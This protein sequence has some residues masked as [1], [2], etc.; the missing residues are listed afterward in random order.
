MKWARTN[1]E[2]L[3]RLK[4][5]GSAEVSEGGRDGV[6]IVDVALVPQESDSRVRLVPDCFRFC[7]RRLIYTLFFRF[8]DGGFSFTD[9]Q[10]YINLYRNS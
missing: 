7:R 4:F 8:F 9:F 2:G 3:G 6:A 10:T 1:E 5:D